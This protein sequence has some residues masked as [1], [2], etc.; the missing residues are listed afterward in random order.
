MTMRW[1]KNP[2]PTGLAGVG[3]GPQGST[4][5]MDGV[6][7]AVVYAHNRSASA[8]YWVAGWDSGVPHKNT[9]ND[10]PQS[11]TDAKAAAMAYVRSHI[12]TPNVI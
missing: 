1:K 10:P 6:V 5:R 9:C 2:R 4:L 7:A 12:K 3:C 8:W 11:E